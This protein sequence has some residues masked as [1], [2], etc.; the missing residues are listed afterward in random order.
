MT[1]R[2]RTGVAWILRTGAASRQ[3]RIG[4]AHLGKDQSW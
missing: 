3:L 4:E 1:V 2:H